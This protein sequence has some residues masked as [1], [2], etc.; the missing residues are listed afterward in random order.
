MFSAAWV[1]YF[2]MVFFIYAKKK[3]MNCLTSL[4]PAMFHV[5]Q[6]MHK[7]EAFDT[8]ADGVNIYG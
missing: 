5:L 3:R 8:A 4:I 2:I 7:H 6:K 1:F